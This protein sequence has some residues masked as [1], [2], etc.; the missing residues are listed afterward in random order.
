MKH[1]KFFEAHQSSHL[2]IVD[3]Q[4]SFSEYFSVQYVE[5]LKTYC[6]SFNSVYQL[7]DNHID[8][9]DV[10]LDYLYEEEPDIPIHNDLY[11]FPNEVELIEKRYNYDVSISFYKSVLT[12]SEYNRI[13]EMEDRKKVE[14]GEMIKTTKGTLLVYV[15]NNHV[16]YHCPKKLYDILSEIK[17]A[18]SNGGSPLIIVG[19]S[20]SECLEDI[21]VCAESL[22]VEISRDYKYIYTATNCP[23]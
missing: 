14:I 4:K 8:G 18:Q 16:W 7:W 12:E 10:D 15:G 19:G 9:K 23:I 6:R 11:R 21:F 5:A 22:G 2:M 13:S 1:I 20:D 3:V 17:V